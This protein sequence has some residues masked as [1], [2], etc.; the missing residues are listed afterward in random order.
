MNDNA[1][2]NQDVFHRL[3]ALNEPVSLLVFKIRPSF[4]RNVHADRDFNLALA[5][6]KTDVPEQSRLLRHIGLLCN[7]PPGTA[8]LLFI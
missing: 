2:A 6:K 1:V 4:L 3:P 7:Q 8:R 5:H